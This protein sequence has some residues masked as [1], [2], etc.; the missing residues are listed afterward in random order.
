VVRGIYFDVAAGDHRTVELEVE[1]LP[2]AR[3]CHKIPFILTSPV[4]VE[5]AREDRVG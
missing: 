1:R 2:H 3:S 4:H 5:E